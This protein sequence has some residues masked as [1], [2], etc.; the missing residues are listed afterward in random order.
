M[1][2]NVIKDDTGGLQELRGLFEK[3]LRELLWAE[4]T[5]I[6][7]LSGVILQSHSTDLVNALE[8]HRA[9][10]ITQ[11]NRLEKIFSIAGISAEEEEY[12]AITCMIKEIE[13][14]IHATRGGVVRDAGIIALLQK[15]CHHEIAC[16][17]TMKAYAM[18]LREEEAI[19]LLEQ[20]LQEEKDA[21]QALTKIAESHINTEAA[22]KEI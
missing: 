5:M 6:K 10:T 7:V 20:T 12:E 9:E 8:N 21:D 22:D 3:Q 17:D 16:D 15:M 11:V 1:I 13:A 18:A 19:G 14:L 4:N 2:S